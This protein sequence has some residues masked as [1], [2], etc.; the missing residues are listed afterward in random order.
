MLEASESPEL[1]ELCLEGVKK[2][3]RIA[4]GLDV[5]VST[6]VLLRL[7]KD[8]FMLILIVFLVLGRARAT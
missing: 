3:V 2:A 1:I 8:C 7:Y 4:G 6:T 5:P